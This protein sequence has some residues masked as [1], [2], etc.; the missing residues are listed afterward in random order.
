[1]ED[2]L[3]SFL[4]TDLEVVLIQHSPNN[5]LLPVPLWGHWLSSLYKRR[6]TGT[7]KVVVTGLKEL[8]LGVKPSLLSPGRCLKIPQNINGIKEFGE[9]FPQGNLEVW[10]EIGKLV[11]YPAA[12]KTSSIKT[13]ES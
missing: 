5:S 2:P 9:P 10:W 6:K 7:Q 8:K 1:M 11:T 12:Y 3:S 13:F 4:G